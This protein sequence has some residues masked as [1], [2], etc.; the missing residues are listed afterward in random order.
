MMQKL[1]FKQ[2]FID[3]QAYVSFKR[4]CVTTY[5]SLI[6]LH[7]SRSFSSFAFDIPATIIL[8]FLCFLKNILL[9]ELNK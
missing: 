2:S 7:I 6:N 9:F 4:R 3:F 8:S 5:I 1:W